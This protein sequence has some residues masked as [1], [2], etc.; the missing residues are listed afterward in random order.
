MM[1]DK[2]RRYDSDHVG[3]DVLRSV[4]GPVEFTQKDKHLAVRL[5]R[6]LDVDQRN[7]M[8]VAAP[9]IGVPKRM[10]SYTLKGYMGDIEGEIPMKGVVCNPEVL[11]WDSSLRT[12]NE[13]CLSFPGKMY[14]VRRPWL[15]R[16]SWQDPSGKSFDV[17]LLGMASRMFQHEIDHL[18]GILV[19]DRVEGGI[20]AYG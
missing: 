20:N 3:T 15:I 2:I 6:A 18:N 7:R 12:A 17:Q 5:L 13:G 4:S 10:F 1:V 14:K 19:I 9:Q 11:E 16:A 8:A